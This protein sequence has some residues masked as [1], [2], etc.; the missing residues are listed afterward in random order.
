MLGKLTTLAGL[1]LVLGFRRNPIEYAVK[2]IQLEF[3]WA[4]I[5]PS[6]KLEWTDCYSAHQ[7]A[8]LNPE[9]EKAAIALTRYP[10]AV[11]ADSP[12]Y[13]GPVLFNPG[14]PGGSGVDMI[15][16]A[17][18]ALAV[19]YIFPS[20]EGVSRST[21]RVSFFE[22][23]MERNAWGNPSLTDL[24]SSSDALGRF[25]ARAQVYNRFAAERSSYQHINTDNTARDM[26][27][28]VRAHGREKLQYWGISY[29]SV[30]GAV[31][32][33]MF[34]DKVERIVID[35]VSAPVA[36]W[37]NNL[38]DTDK[39]LQA[40]FDGCVA[41][42]PE[43]CA[44]HAPTPEAISKNLTTLFKSIQTRP[45][46]VHGPPGDWF[47]VTLY[48]PYSLFSP[49]AAL[50]AAL[51]RGDEALPILLPIPTFECPSDPAE[52]QFDNV[53]DSQVAII[54][55]DGRAVPSG[56]EEA[57]KHYQM[58]AKTSSWG[59]ILAS[60]RIMCSGW[61]DTPKRHFQGPVTG[62]TSFPLLIIG[63]TADPITP[64]QNAKKMSKA[65][66]GS[67][68]LT[69]DCPGH[70]SLAGASP[71]TWGYIREYF[72]DGT[73]PDNDTVCPVLGSLF[74][75][76]GATGLQEHEQT[77]FSAARRDMF[78]FEAFETVQSSARRSMTKFL[79]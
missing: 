7:C 5:V 75:N 31:F 55:N 38:L 48:W 45:I 69:Q 74:P 4:S 66:T 16:L 77:V 68:V 28:I 25:W 26:L 1:L 54:C 79:L 9:G 67:V 52:H 53:A 63:N 13:R 17:G 14:G 20:F 3:S 47:C 56:F 49:V 37:S 76:P 33:S 36:L 41:A 32:A 22:T 42:G 62:N 34:P 58:M 78:N 18:S 43:A 29:G 11:P 8:R 73:L 65:F 57:E 71:C 50:L 27:Q 72:L 51:A 40:F 12:L 60:V 21:P 44:F 10:A 59:S 46:P 6:D 19:M 35:G 24:N 2:N 64:L 30:L 61:P 15:A 23:N 70:T 39:A